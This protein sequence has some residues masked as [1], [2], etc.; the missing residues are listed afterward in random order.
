MDRP[1]RVAEVIETS[2]DSFTSQCYRFD[3]GLPLGSFVAVGKPSTYAVISNI[4]SGPLDPGR[5]V[6][7]RGS[8]EESEESL[9]LNHPQLEHLLIT[10]MEAVIIGYEGADG[11]YHGLP[12]LPPRLHS[13]VYTCAADT[14]QAL[15]K[16]FNFLQLLTST[17]SATRDEALAS[18]LRQASSA[19]PQPMEFLLAAG[20][21]LAQE[22][23][24]DLRRL[25]A[26]LR[27]ITR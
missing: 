16:R 10:R 4:V 6:T 21:A 1:R 7:A 22:L 15:T 5:R 27:R 26:L 24:D 3:G 17:Q 13:F 11:I 20:R 8:H 2:S 23:S 25:N 18:C 19:H 12:P 9:F 14:I